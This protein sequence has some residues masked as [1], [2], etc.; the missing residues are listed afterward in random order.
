MRVLIIFEMMYIQIFLVV[1]FV[2]ELYVDQ[3]P[4]HPVMTTLEYRC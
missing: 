1:G 4:V 2:L 3:L